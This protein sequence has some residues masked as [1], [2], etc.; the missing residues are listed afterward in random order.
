MDQ[1]V[2]LTIKVR[3]G[4]NLVLLGNKKLKVE[5]MKGVGKVYMEFNLENLLSFQD[6]SFCFNA[7]TDFFL[8]NIVG[9]NATVLSDHSGWILLASN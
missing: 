9:S 8:R 4:V 3:P 1:K 5:D 2:P 7:H 6:F